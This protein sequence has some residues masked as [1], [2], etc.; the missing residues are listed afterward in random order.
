MNCHVIAIDNG[1]K[2]EICDSLGADHF[3]DF[4]KTSDLA[5]A[6]KEILSESNA[7]KSIVLALVGTR[8]AYREGMKMLGYGG[9]F[10]CVGLRKW[11]VLRGDRAHPD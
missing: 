4:T 10:V 5:H 6:V 3:I 9:T 7:T 8:E 11:N 2:R 1:T